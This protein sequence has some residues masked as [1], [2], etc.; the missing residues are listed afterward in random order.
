MRSTYV[1]VGAYMCTYLHNY[2]QPLFREREVLNQFS[3]QRYL[4]LDITRVHG[5]SLKDSLCR[6]ESL[7]TKNKRLFFCLLIGL[8]NLGEIN[9]SLQAPSDRATEGVS[10]LRVGSRMQR[11]RTGRFL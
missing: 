11:A 7:G 4:D 10:T 2:M 1:P 3:P 5:R 9:A 8:K 6:R